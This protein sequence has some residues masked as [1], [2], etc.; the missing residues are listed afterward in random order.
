[1]DKL[2]TPPNAIDLT[3]IDA[4]EARLESASTAASENLSRGL[5]DGF[6]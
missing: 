4:E 3:E 1:M 2:K 5:L 6:I